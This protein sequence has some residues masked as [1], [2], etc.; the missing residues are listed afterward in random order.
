M[1]WR[2]LPV[3]NAGITEALTAQVT[4]D[5]LLSHLLA[6]RGVKDFSGA[7]EF[8]RPSIAHLHDPYRMKDMDVAV[9]RIEKARITQEHLMVYGDYDVDG[10]TSVALVSEFLDGKFP[11]EAYIPDRYKEGYGLSFDGINTAAELGI[12]LI[13][14]LDCGIKAF[15]QINHANSLGIDIIVCDHHRP[16]DELP[17]AKAILNPKRV[18]CLYP[19][20]ELSGCGVGFKLCQ[21]LCDRWGLPLEHY[22]YPLL[23]LCAISIAADIVH[24]SGENRIMASHGMQLLRTGACRPGLLALIESAGKTPETLSFR[25]LSF[26]I[27]PRINAAGRMESGLRAVELLRSK[28]QGEQ[29]ELAAAI[30]VFNTDRRAAQGEI[31]EQAKEQLDTALYPYSNVLYA[32][33]WH[34]GVVGIVASKIVEHHYRPTIILTKS[35]DKLA[36]SA[37][38]VI[39]FDL[40]EA[41]SACEQHLI[42]FG[43]HKYAAG[44]T[45]HESQ[46][47]HFKK[48][49][50]N[51]CKAHLKPEQ[52]VP[53]LLYDAQTH[54]SQFNDRFHKIMVQLEP[55]G[56]ENPTPVFLLK[57]LI[58]A[59]KTKA[60][61]SDSSHL[62]LHIKHASGGPSISGIAFGKGHL[63]T[64]FA[65]GKSFDALV[66]LTLNY[67]R[68]TTSLEVMVVDI[69]PQ[70]ELL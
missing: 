26:T 4:K 37:R 67:Y 40:Y 42:Q 5:P 20:K 6:S 31:F 17:K 9:E 45:L 14:A 43:G 27:G 41:L 39:D 3:P 65:E 61:G 33:H 22:L 10:T 8:F 48:A 13:I 66:S 46:L 35:G 36:G 62:K 2:S 55:H 64:D 51:Y 60:V 53:E 68:G 59:G 44:M 49:F 11:I 56:P 47:P 58:D 12:T 70:Q 15:D 54:L 50:E 23:D 57:D 16:D 1:R 34:K 25:D 52:L 28:Q 69:R 32:P 30:H 63:A 21:G 24:I 19:Y 18:D 38:S 29:Q 7:K